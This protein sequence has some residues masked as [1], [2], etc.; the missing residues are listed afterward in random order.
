MLLNNLTLTYTFDTDFVYFLNFKIIIKKKIRI[1]MI[2][3]NFIFV[4]KSTRNMSENKLEIC[5][6]R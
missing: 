1:S 4:Q 3:S 2:D 6:I 5:R